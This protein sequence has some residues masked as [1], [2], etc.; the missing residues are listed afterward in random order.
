MSLT[1]CV[2][3]HVDESSS[4]PAQP[5]TPRIIS[6]EAGSCTSLVISYLRSQGLFPDPDPNPNEAAASST[7]I[8]LQQISSLALSAILIDTNNLKSPSKTKPID[9]EAVQFLTSHLGSHGG[10]FTPPSLINSSSSS[11]SEFTSSSSAPS[12]ISIFFTTDF[13]RLL[14]DAKLHSLD[15]LTSAEILDRDYKQCKTFISSITTFSQSHTLDIFFLFTS[16][17]L[18]SGGGSSSSGDGDRRGKGLLA[19]AFTSRGAAVLERPTDG[20][21]EDEDEDDSHDNKL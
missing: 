9:L 20:E 14:S 16:A 4:P 1:G 7:T 2:D 5:Y 8:G 13:H 19:V 11:S 15:K 6:L 12:S 3:H 10:V 17:A 18:I 21:N